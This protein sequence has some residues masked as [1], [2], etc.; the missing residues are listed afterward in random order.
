MRIPYLICLVLAGLS[1][2]AGQSH[3]N[4]MPELPKDPR[5]M[6]AAAAAL[7][8]FNSP[9]LIPWRLKGTYQLYDESGNVREHGTYEYWW[10]SP[11]VYRSSWT[12]TGASRTEWHMDD[13][14]ILYQATGDRMFYFEHELE[15][16]LLS[17]VPDVTKL[18]PANVEVEKDELKVGKAK[19]SCANVKARLNPDGETPKHPGVP[20]GDYC[21]DPSTPVLRIVRLFNSV[22]V[23]FDNLAKTQNRILSREIEISDGRHKLLTFTVETT[24]DL[25]KDD[26]ALAPPADARPV[27]RQNLPS[28]VGSRQAREESISCVPACGQ[29]VP[30]HWHCNSGRNDR[31]RRT[32]EGHSCAGNAFAHFDH[33][34]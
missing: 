7:Y 18:D 23:G 25:K 15:N 13:G 17:P 1:S 32:S 30:H 28:V 20:A 16:L 2:V 24:L 27:T 33:C 3:S 19:L 22:V 4:S 14:K 5:Q 6:L 31:D 8:D 9:S 11:T 12:R 34:G 10:V 21:F 26:A 29:G